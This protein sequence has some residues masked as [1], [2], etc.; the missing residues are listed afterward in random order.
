M[1]VDNLVLLCR[2]SVGLL[3]YL[4]VKCLPPKTKIC[5]G[6]RC[7][8]IEVNGTDGEIFRCTIC[9]K[10]YSIRTGSFSQKSKLPLGTLLMAIWYFCE[11]TSV[12]Q[13]CKYM[14]GKIS[15]PSVILWF[16]Y[17]RD[18]CSAW[19]LK[20]PIIFGKNKRSI[21]QVDESFIGAKRKYSKGRLPERNDETV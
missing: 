21:I 10:K 20:Y 6:E 12:T 16:N 19:L 15:K 4:R 7:N 3:E 9:W 14:R 1:N 11:N 8:L 17:C 13:T 2:S 18:I 5:C